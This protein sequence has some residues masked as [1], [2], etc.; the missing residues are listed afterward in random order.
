ML[1]HLGFGVSDVATSKAFFTVALAPLGYTAVM[2][3]IGGVGIGI[4]RPI[5]WLAAFV[6]GPDG[7]NLEGVCHT[8]HRAECGQGVDGFCFIIGSSRID[9][10][11]R[12]SLHRANSTRCLRARVVEPSAAQRHR[13]G[14]SSSPRKPLDLAVRSKR[15]PGW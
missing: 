5:L 9:H 1:D 6:I 14:G 13:D 3:G 7:H 8:A 12:R 15:A 11:A 4:G 2:E 10:R